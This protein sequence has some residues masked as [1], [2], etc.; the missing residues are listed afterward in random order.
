[1]FHPLKSNIH[2]LLTSIFFL[3]YISFTSIP[4]Q[5]SWV[6]PEIIVVEGKPPYIHNAP[7]QSDNPEVVN[8]A[9]NDA[10]NDKFELVDLKL[11]KKG[12]WQTQLKIKKTLDREKQAFYHFTLEALDS[13]GNRIDSTALTVRVL[14]VNDNRP[15]ITNNR[16]E[17]YKVEEGK[18]KFDIFKLIV[19]DFDDP[20][21]SYGINS[22]Q[23]L[24]PNNL[25]IN[26][27]DSAKRA[28]EKIDDRFV[29]NWFTVTDEGTVRTTSFSKIDAELHES[30][31]MDFR[32]R[33]T[34]ACS[35]E[36][37]TGSTCA[38][39]ESEVFTAK[40]E[41]QDVN[42]NIPKFPAPKK[43]Y[44]KVKE[45]ALKDSEIGEITVIDNDVTVENREIEFKIKG[46][47]YKDI[48]NIYT[49]AENRVV[50]RIV[51]ANSGKLDYESRRKYV[52]DVEA[53]NKNPLGLGVSLAM[54][55][56][57]RYSNERCRLD[58]L[59]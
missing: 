40:I 6:Y 44:F 8:Y 54:H 10:P 32:V 3:N 36:N 34:K 50:G 12:Q 25:R 2:I 52:F 27:V 7:F 55:D 38:Q 9:I 37:G 23:Y 57:S 16:E 13:N 43:F 11:N 18:Q 15:I 14:D 29:E 48:F 49:S 21:D 1:M 56:A 31:L 45:L 26:F 41:V 33:D 51:L 30:F 28:Q 19:K 4:V 47:K 58:F 17:V 5:A 35:Q 39:K 22:I 24:P 42:D 46:G 20:N 59:V 53:K